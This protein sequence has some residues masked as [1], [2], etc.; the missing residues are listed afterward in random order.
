[1]IS[2]H[3]LFCIFLHQ[4]QPINLFHCCHIFLWLCAWSGCS[5]VCCRFRICPGK[6]F[7]FLLLLCSL[8]MCANNRVH[9]DPMVVFL[10]LHITLPHYHHYSDLPE[11]IGLLKC[12]SGTFCLE[13]VSKIKSILSIIFHAIYG[14]VRIQLA[15]FSC[16]G[17]E[18]TCTLSY[19]HHRIGSMAHL[20]LFK[21]K[22]WNNGMRWMSFYILIH[23][24]NVCYSLR[25][26][27]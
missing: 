26:H 10:C 21:V 25:K 27:L 7:F 16:D 8:T 13:C 17:C 11:G 19:Y 2:D 20:P 18:D 12:L 9:Y 6:L 1:M 3:L 4:V 22:S 14:A 15:H 24:C 23:K 5:I